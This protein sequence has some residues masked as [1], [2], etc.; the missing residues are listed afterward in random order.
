[1][2]DRRYELEALPLAKGGM[3]EVWVGRD[4]KLDREIAVK[5][6]RFPDGRP[7]DELVRRFI[8]ESRITA[9]LVHPGVPAV[10]DAGTHER[11]PYLVMQRVHG[12]SVADLVAEQGALPIGWAA[13]IA[14]QAASVLAVAHRASLVHRDLKPANLMLEPDG[15][16]KVLDFGLAVALDRTDLSKITLTGQHLGSPAYMAPEQVLAGVSA[17]ATD[18]YGLGATLFEMLTGRRLFAGSS[19]YSVMH[20]QVEEVPERVRTLRADVPPGLD[21]LVADLLRKAPEERPSGAEAVYEALIGWVTDLVPL[22]GIVDPAANN[23]VRM[24][25]RVAARVHPPEPASLVPAPLVPAPSVPASAAQAPP[26]QGPDGSGTDGSE[27]ASSDTMTTSEWRSSSSGG[28][29]QVELR[30]ARDEARSL[31]RSSRYDQATVI[32]TEAVDR[33][34]RALGADS[35]DVLALRLELAELLFEG[36]DFRRAVGE[37]ERLVADL[38]RR[39]GRDSER[40]ML[41]RLREATC[42][43]LIGETPR[44]LEQLGALLPDEARAFG[45][46]DPRVLELRRQIGLLQLGAGHRAAAAETLAALLAD[47]LRVW[48]PEHPMVPVVRE[49]LTSADAAAAR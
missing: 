13:A 16:V 40:L 17:P 35:A 2:I 37:Y 27:P 44:A 32:L 10:Y 43:A 18:L 8:R 23:T 25:D 34:G 48:G 15:T 22:P 3:G 39:D 19:S 21:G 20:Q 45:A 30:Q 12:I 24:Y 28:I 38:S 6:V 31:A 9:R 7:D 33:A 11:R 47:L 42:R 4:V 5:F 1:M 41:A 49:L 26:E 14:A 29:G 46:D 36:G